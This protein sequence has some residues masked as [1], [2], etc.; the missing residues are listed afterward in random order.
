MWL[1]VINMVKVTHQVEGHI[2]VKVKY[3]T[4]FQFYV[5]YFVNVFTLKSLDDTN[6]VKVTLRSM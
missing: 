5:M 1:Q 6:K 3:L 2:K 4:P